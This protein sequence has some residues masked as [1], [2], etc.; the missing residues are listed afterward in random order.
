MEAGVA[1]TYTLEVRRQRGSE[2][3]LRHLIVM[4][5]RLDPPW[6]SK[7]RKYDVALPRSFDTASVT[8]ELGD[9]GQN[10]FA[11]LSDRSGRRL[12]QEEKV[13]VAPRGR[14]LL[15]SGEFQYPTK[16]YV[17]PIPLDTTRAVDIRVTSADGSQKGYYALIITREGCPQ[18]RNI[19]D[20]LSKE[21]VR[22]CATGFFAN[23]MV[24]RCERCKTG[25][26]NCVGYRQ[27]VQCPPDNRQYRFEL[28]D[29]NNGTCVSTL[30]PFWEQHAEQTAAAG[31]SAF[32]ILVFFA[33]L[34]GFACSSAQAR[35]GVK[36][37]MLRP[38]TNGGG[39][40]SS[41]E[42]DSSEEDPRWGGANRY[43]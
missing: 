12:E 25:C 23:D 21:C 40:T 14:R 4:G 1:K 17:F 29:Y 36:L 33:G 11:T 30:R 20:P 8:A 37:M 19:F 3:A 18:E 34:V 7:I 35:P 6:D 32:C 15:H 31:V 13:V 26:I 28:P 27:C 24:G 39:G 43:A 22:F 38:G 2:T 42:S 41:D 10:M 9:G 5:G 16:D